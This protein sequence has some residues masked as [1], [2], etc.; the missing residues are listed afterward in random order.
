MSITLS[1]FYQISSSV[2]AQNR[3]IIFTP[4]CMWGTV[5]CHFQLVLRSKFGVQCDNMSKLDLLLRNWVRNIYFILFEI[6][7]GCLDVLCLL[8]YNLCHLKAIL[9]ITS[10]VTN[11]HLNAARFQSG[12]LRKI[13]RKSANSMV[14]YWPISNFVF[15]PSGVKIES[16][17]VLLFPN[18][19]IGL[20]K[21]CVRSCKLSFL[22]SKHPSLCIG[23]EN[24]HN[25]FLESKIV[26]RQCCLS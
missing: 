11:I 15:T 14:F 26:I 4:L 23:L 13:V 1:H 2:A 18:V 3:R 25:A 8:K 10:Q 6:I 24:L 7:F 22:L 19:N 17:L 21:S 9:S 20:I 5:T 12:S 16:C